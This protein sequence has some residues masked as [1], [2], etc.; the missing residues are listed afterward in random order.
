MTAAAFCGQ[1]EGQGVGLTDMVGLV[2]PWAPLL[3]LLAVMV[4]RGLANPDAKRLYD[5]LLSNYNRLIRPVANNTDKITVK[6]GLKLSQ[7]VD[8]DLKN[9]ILTTNLWVETEWH[10]D[11]LQWDPDEYGGVEE[12]YVPSEIIWLPDIILYNNADGNY[13]ITTMTKATLYHDG[14]VKWEPPAIFKSS[15]DIDVRYFPFDEQTCWLK[16]GSWTFDGF[17]IDLIHI[18]ANASSEDSSEEERRKSDHVE[19]GIDLT[20]YYINVEWDILRVP[21]ERHVKIY[22]CCPEPYPD[23]FFYLKIRRKPLFYIVNLIIPCV[24]IFYL[25]I[26]VFY[27]P[28][29]SGEKTALAIAILV[30]Q[31]L[32]FTLVIE[33]IP[34]TSLTLP[35]LGRYLLFSMVLVAVS[36]CLATIV[37][38]LHYRKPSTHKM[39]TWVRA[40]LIQKMPGILLMRVPKQ[41]VKATNGN[42]RSKYLRQVDPSLAELAEESNGAATGGLKENHLGVGGCNTPDKLNG[43]LKNH[44]DSIFSG[45]QKLISGSDGSIERRKLPFVIE[46]TIHN[47]LFIKT[48]MERQD[49]FDAE[50]QDWGIVAMVLDRMFLWVFGAAA[51]VGSTMI[52]TESPSLFDHVIPIDA[53]ITTIGVDSPVESSK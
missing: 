36:V 39:P 16:F 31:T 29:Q 7:L 24:G 27:L 28:A 21:A 12:I 25:S 4:G 53:L 48:H 38:N 2:L 45:F 20:E 40:V 19:Q 23:I 8:L 18:H 41:V 44:L 43:Q 15:C 51:V 14:L 3:A 10:D 34:A 26:L 17:Q 49:E 22:A 11:K 35:L 52:L 32:Y 50:D 37:L 46:K 30:S 33:V 6:M 5:D 47:I 42:R 13:H 1:H 9:Q